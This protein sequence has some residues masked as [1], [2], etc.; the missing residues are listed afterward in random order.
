MRSQEEIGENVV[1]VEVLWM[2]ARYENGGRE[3]ASMADL[4]IGKVVDMRCWECGCK[5]GKE[6]KQYESEISMRHIDWK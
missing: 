2:V 1:R 5:V 6:C 4:L 3:D